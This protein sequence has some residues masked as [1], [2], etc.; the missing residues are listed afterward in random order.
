M[1]KLI[2]GEDDNGNV[3]LNNKVEDMKFGQLRVVILTELI[4]IYDEDGNGDVQLEKCFF[5]EDI[6]S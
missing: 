6:G 4:M 2:K 1:I 3:Q 5:I